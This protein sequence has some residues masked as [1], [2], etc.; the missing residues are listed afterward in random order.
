MMIVMV[1]RLAW[2]GDMARGSLLIAVVSLFR[3]QRR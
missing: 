2:G 3:L 1:I